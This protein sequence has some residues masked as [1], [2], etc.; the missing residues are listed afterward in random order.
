MVTM[1]ENETERRMWS[2]TLWVII[3]LMVCLWG[4]D[5]FGLEIVDSQGNTPPTPIEVAVGE[6]VDLIVNGLT[7]HCTTIDE[8][9]EQLSEAR[10]KATYWPREK[11]R[12]KMTLDWSFRPGFTFEAQQQ[13]DYFVAVSSAIQ[14][15]LGYDEVHIRVGEGGPP[16]PPPPPGPR[17]VVIYHESSNRPPPV[18]ETVLRRYLIESDHTFRWVD[19]T[20]V[21]ADDQP[22]KPAATI[23]RLM[24]E[25]G[26]KLPVIVVAEQGFVVHG[27]SE[28]VFAISELPET[29]GEAIEFVK[30][31]E[32]E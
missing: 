27:E 9:R 11:A 7:D 4:W 22:T 28:D 24:A 25:R 3:F 23:K 30:K 21:G 1:T 10:A 31:W 8:V 32:G 6:D 19:Q 29:A 17:D 18:L 2:F 16:P 12:L 20:W 13:G 14:G 15:D 5:V 26:L